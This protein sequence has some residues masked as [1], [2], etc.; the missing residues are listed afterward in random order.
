VLAGSSANAGAVYTLS[1]GAG[2]PDVV[3]VDRA[4]TDN[5]PSPP[6]VDELAIIGH[7]PTGSI[8]TGTAPAYV[9]SVT[10]NLPMTAGQT[11]QISGAVLESGERLYISPSV[12]DAIDAVAYGVEIS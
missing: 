2:Y 9:N 1:G 12:A 4:N 3:L 7:A 6:T 8:G 5:D 10:S 11:L